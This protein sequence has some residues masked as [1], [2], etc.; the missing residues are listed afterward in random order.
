MQGGRRTWPPEQNPD[1]GAHPRHQEDLTS[2]LFLWQHTYSR[3]R[4]YPLAIRRACN[5]TQSKAPFDPKVFLS[6]INGGR[7]ISDYRK[8]K[9]VYGRATLRIPFSTFRPARSRR[10]SSPSWARKRRS[11]SS[12]QTN[13][14]VEEACRDNHAEALSHRKARFDPLVE[15]VRPPSPVRYPGGG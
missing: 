11:Q 15:D 3:P 8:E 5:E 1:D 7:V 13:S 14:S 10:P 2:A 4:E 12:V 9:I 6:K